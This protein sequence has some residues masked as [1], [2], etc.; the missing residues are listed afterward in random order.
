LNHSLYV[1]NYRLFLG[2]L[3]SNSIFDIGYPVKL[4]G[5]GLVQSLLVTFD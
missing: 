1:N 3:T 5:Q 2:R 4:E